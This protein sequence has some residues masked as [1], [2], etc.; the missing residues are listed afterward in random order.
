MTKQTIA[1]FHLELNWHYHA[2]TDF[3]SF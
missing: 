1:A 2:T 3:C